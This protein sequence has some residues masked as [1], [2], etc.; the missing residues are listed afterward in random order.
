MTALSRKSLPQA[1]LR[2]CRPRLLPSNADLAPRPV[3]RRSNPRERRR[4]RWSMLFRSDAF[5]SLLESP[6]GMRS[7]KFPRSARKRT[8]S[9]SAA[10]GSNSAAGKSSHC[11]AN[12]LATSSLRLASK[13]AIPSPMLRSVASRSAFFRASSRLQSSTVP[14]WSL[15]VWK[16]PQKESG[17]VPSRGRSPTAPRGSSYATGGGRRRQRRLSG[18]QRSPRPEASSAGNPR[19]R[20]VFP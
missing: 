14:C 8:R 16:S 2:S 18:L 1:Y 10:P 15:Y 13:T 20:R 19:G 17:R 7:P 3:E 9:S 4:A 11:T 12:S 6:G 5:A